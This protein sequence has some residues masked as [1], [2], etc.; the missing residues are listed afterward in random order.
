MGRAAFFFCVNLRSRMPWSKVDGSEIEDCGDDQ[1]AVVKDEDR[2]LEGCHDTEDEADEQIAALEASEDERSIPDQHVR[3][4]E[5]G[6]VLERSYTGIVE[7]ADS[8]EPIVLR[9]N[10][11]TTTDAHGTRF[12]MDGADLSRFKDNPIVRF[13]HGEDPVTGR[14]PVAR[15]ENVQ[16]QGDDLIATLRFDKQDETAQK[17]ESK[18]RRGFLNAGSI[19]AAPTAKPELR[20][21]GGEDV[22]AFPEWELRGLSVV[23]IPSNPDA[24]A[25]SRDDDQSALEKRLERLERMMVQGADVD[26]DSES[27]SVSLGDVRSSVRSRV[28]DMDG[29]NEDWFVK[30]ITLD[31][32]GEGVAQGTVIAYERESD[33][34]FEMSFEYNGDNVT[35]SDRDEWTEVT[36]TWVPVEDM[37]RMIER[38]R[39]LS[40][41]ST[42]DVLTRSEA[43]EAVATV[44]AEYV[45]RKRNL[46]EERQNQLRQVTKQVL[47]KA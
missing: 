34:A 27:R 24:T 29:P 8:E 38:K 26:E 18:L 46:R 25:I 35:L 9:F 13:A 4:Y 17:V 47:G 42:S 31:S 15:A 6:D 7:R 21:A 32:V 33:Q 11:G 3:A 12:D 20:S 45:Q 36:E 19:A 5:Q 28:Y 30:D 16:V 44:V 2:S 22:V 23:D 43:T 40:S 10:R 37:D 1:V 41:T 39:S 14:M